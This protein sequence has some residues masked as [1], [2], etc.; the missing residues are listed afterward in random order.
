M[1]LGHTGEGHGPGDPQGDVNQFLSQHSRA[2]HFLFCDGHVRLI[3]GA[4]DYP[5]IQGHGRDPRNGVSSRGRS[6]IAGSCLLK[7]TA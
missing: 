5:T 4:I 7:T 3:Q 1:L 2:A 6:Q